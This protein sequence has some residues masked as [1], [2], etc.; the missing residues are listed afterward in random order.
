[1]QELRTDDLTGTHVIVAPGRATRPEVYSSPAASATGAT[2]TAPPPDCPFCPG[3]EATTPPEVARVGAGEPDTPGWQVRVVPNLYPVVGQEPGI[4]GA[5]EVIVLSPDHYRQLDALP[6]D[7]AAAVFLALR[8][9]AA[10]HLDA[11]FAHAQ[12]LVN[13]GRAAGASIEHPHA[14]L[15]ALAFTPPHVEEI[16]TRFSDAGRDLVVDALEEAR[17]GTNLVGDSGAVSWCPRGVALPPFSVR[18]AL[19]S[20]AGRFDRSTD[21]ESRA[22]T[23]GLTDGLARLHTVLGE[24]AYNVVVNTAPRDDPRP[25][26]CWIDIVPRLGVPAGFELGTGV[27]VNPVDPDAAA[28]SAA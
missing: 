23:E 24:F 6:A 2:A 15:V 4:P 26:H 17:R 5:H 9:R 8:D 10:H 25:F 18:V 13:H 28:A 27:L 7:G 19:P 20:G 21:D 3:H 1:M 12:V 16:L 11:G 14:Q 22:L